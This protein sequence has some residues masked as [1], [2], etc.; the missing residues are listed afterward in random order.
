MLTPE[1]LSEKVNEALRGLHWPAA[2][3]GL[4][5]PVSYALGMGGKRLRPVLLLLAYQLYRD[6]TDAAMPAAIGLETYH[7]HTL[8]H[9]DVMD[10]AD[11]RRGQP[12]V[13]RKWNENTAILSGDVM[14]VM[15]LRHVLACRCRRSAEAAELFLR[16]AQEVCEGQQHDMNFETRD[17]VDV[18]EYMEM[19]RLKT[20]VLLAC[21]ARMGAL[22]ADAP[23][24]DCAA[25]YEFAEKTGLAFQLQDDY[26]DVYGD[27]LVFGKKT[28]GDILCGKKTFLLINALDRADAATRARLLSLLG[29][30]GMEPAA[31]ISAV[32]EIYDAAGIKELCAAAI[33]RHYGEALRCLS[34]LD[35]PEERIAPLRDFAASLLHRRA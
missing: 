16:T 1:Q 6:D 31:K 7:N 27:P 24:S 28:G 3:E 5:E 17:S 23:E 2:P 8:L 20:S 34:R 11:L 30:S 33:E 25:L 9:D 35:A 29:D 13:C 26:L 4:Y 22:I 12:T 10:K 14:L 15:S 18:A 21:A 32:T 19:I